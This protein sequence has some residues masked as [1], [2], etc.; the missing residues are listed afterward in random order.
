VASGKSA[1]DWLTGWLEDKI[2]EEPSIRT[3]LV[4]MQRRISASAGPLGR[5]QTLVATR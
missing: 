4:V 3:C 1:T 5:C 2:D